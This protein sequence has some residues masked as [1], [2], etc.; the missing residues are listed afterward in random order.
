MQSHRI[1]AWINGGILSARLK[2]CPARR[3][4]ENSPAVPAVMLSMQGS[5]DYAG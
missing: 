1:G 2:P 3:L 4:H 5:F